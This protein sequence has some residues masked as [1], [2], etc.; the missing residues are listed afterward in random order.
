M[1]SRIP[2]RNDLDRKAVFDSRI[3]SGTGSKEISAKKF[4]NAEDKMPVGDCLEDFF[5]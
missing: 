4:R 5:A 2:S 3:N 1:P